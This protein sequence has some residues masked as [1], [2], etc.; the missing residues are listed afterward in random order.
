M[1]PDNYPIVDSTIRLRCGRTLGLMETGPKDGPAVFHFHGHGSSRLEV[2]LLAGAAARLGVRLVGFDRPS[3]GRSDK[4]PDFRILDW[5]DDVQEVADRLGIERFAVEGLSAGGIYALA[6]A[7]RIPHRLTACGLISS[8]VPRHLIMKAGPLWMRTVWWL[9]RRFPWL[10]LPTIRVIARAAATQANIDAWLLRFSPLLGEPD[11]RLLARP[12]IRSIFAEAVVEGFRQKRKAKPPEALA[13][14]QPWGFEIEKIAFK[15]I[16]L[17][18]G[19]QDRII[20]PTLAHLL[21]QGLPQCT[22]TFYPDDG[23]ISL[24]ANHAQDIL[25]V[26]RA[27][28][29]QNRSISA[30]QPCVSNE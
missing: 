16:F 13:D 11:Q 21:A 6:C 24:F 18:H 7:Y 15:K 8:A 10:F 20:S 28:K 22:A 23:H 27:V 25:K 17:W 12:D 3:V 5:P 9:G 26:M 2:R 30:N 19:D 1:S 29:D 14:F 4:K